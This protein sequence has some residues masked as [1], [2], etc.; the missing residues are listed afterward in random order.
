LNW[1]DD[2]YHYLTTYLVVF[3]GKS[4]GS[5]F[6]K[7]EFI[8]TDDVGSIV[9]WISEKNRDRRSCC[10]TAA[11]SNA[12][13]IARAALEMG[14]SLKGTKFI[15]AG[16]PYTGTK[17]EIIER[18]GATGIARY[19]YG[20][21]TNIG[22]G[23]ANPIHTDEIHVNQHMLALIP[24]PNACNNRGRPIYPLLCS[25]LDPI[26]TRLLLNVESGDYA[27]FEKRNCGCALEKAGLE[28][29]LHRIRSFEKFTSEGMSYTFTDLF[30]LLEKTLPMEFGGTS[31]DYQ[32][33]EE[34]DRNGQTR[35]SIVVHPSLGIIS[36]E[37]LIFRIRDALGENRWFC[38]FW[39]DADTFRVKRAVPYASPRGKILP[40]HIAH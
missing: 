3:L 35:I 11:A 31:G 13:R 17:R 1:Y 10:I 22:Y 28:L 9:N 38:R 32:L 34:E 26:S 27:N 2:L 24:H 40:L 33:V 20:G 14:V 7:P 36:E 16:E 29:H 30:E 4:V 18:A 21:S 6:P 39:R 12:T 25:T 8:G 15:C 37:K 5:G 19:A 23:C